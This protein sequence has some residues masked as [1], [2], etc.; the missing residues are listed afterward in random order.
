MSEDVVEQPRGFTLLD[1][2]VAA[3]QD[4]C[5]HRGTAL[6][7]GEIPIDLRDELHLKVPDANAFM[8][9]RLLSRIKGIAPHLP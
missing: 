4:L 8:Y 2:Q 5:I 6:S 1:E 9:R 7:L 3:F